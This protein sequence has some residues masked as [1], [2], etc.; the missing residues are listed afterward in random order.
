MDL[1]RNVKERGVKMTPRLSAWASDRRIEKTFPQ[2]GLKPGCSCCSHESEWRGYE[3]WKTLHLISHPVVICW[4][5]PI[6][7]PCNKL[8]RQ[9]LDLR[10]SEADLHPAGS[11]LAYV[12]SKRHSHVRP[13]VR[14]EK[15]WLP[16]E[17]SLVKP[18]VNLGFPPLICNTTLT[19]VYFERS[20]W[21]VE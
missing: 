5:H 21:V 19:V 8:P 3:H 12:G 18:D 15:K 9:P 4:P 1:T 16:H 6:T 20:F 11:L 13:L 17:V 14:V 2:R 10:C 7:H